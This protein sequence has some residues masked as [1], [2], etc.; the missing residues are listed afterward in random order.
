MLLS[1]NKAILPS[2]SP[3]LPA[4]LL[5]GVERLGSRQAADAT[6]N[7]AG[8]LGQ[9]GLGFGAHE[10]AGHVQ[11]VHGHILEE[12]KERGKGARE[13]TMREGGEG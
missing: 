12:G 1:T 6:V 11:V 5:T 8:A 13:R 9:Y 10:K 3:S 4:S 2:L 7:V